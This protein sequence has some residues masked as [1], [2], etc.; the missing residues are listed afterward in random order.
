M[1]RNAGFWEQVIDKNSLKMGNVSQTT[2]LVLAM[3]LGN[4]LAVKVWNRT[5]IQFGSSTV[6][7]PDPL[8]LVGAKPE[9][10]PIYPHV[11]ADLATPV[12]SIIWLTILYFLFMF[13]FRYSTVNLKR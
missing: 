2:Q 3:G 10:L 11:S 5:T 13:T 8:F 12:G 4:M 6:Q 9:S 1:Q 7:K